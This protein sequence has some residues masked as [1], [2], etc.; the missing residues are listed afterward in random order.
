MS[1]ILFIKKNKLDE[2]GY[3]FIQ[4]T[5]SNKTKRVSLKVKMLQTHF[6]K[7]F[8][9]DFQ[10]FKKTTLLDYQYINNLIDESINKDVFTIEANQYKDTFLSYYKSRILLKSNQ[11][12]ISV[13]TSAYNLLET[14][15]K[16]I[17]K[18]E[19][20]MSEIDKDFVLQLKTYLL[21]G[22]NQNTC[23][24][25]LNAYKTIINNA[26]E[27]NQ[28]ILANP[29]NNVKFKI[30]AKKKRVLNITDINTLLEID[31]DEKYFLA[32]R[33]FLLQFFLNGSRLSDTL[34][35]KNSDI[36]KSEI[37]VIMLKT[38]EYK[39]V[40]M[41][42]EIAVLLFEI[43]F[44]KR[45]HH[46]KHGILLMNYLAKNANEYV[47]KDFI[48][49]N[50]FENYKKENH[51][52][53]EQHKYYKLLLTKYDTQ[54]KKLSKTYELSEIISSHNSRH[55][56]TNEILKLE[57]INV[58]DIRML[59]GHSNIATTQNYIQTGFQSEKTDDLQKEYRSKYDYK[60]NKTL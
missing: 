15:L 6:D 53:I 12:T 9:K 7:T 39:P 19:L 28:Y 33:L 50:I 60:F 8:N 32:S 14:Y 34:L 23:K 52:T 20:K 26:I 31:F 59:L 27:A 47:F 37:S 30:T 54:L 57:N 42:R 21:I 35:L 48:K 24:T 51:F 44:R 5:K 46:S 16:S 55:T 22:R 25:Y 10:R 58:N 2:F 29:F 41:S 49:S 4:Y 3:I 40:S 1:S 18:V 43:V 45:Y 56:F 13:Y 38:K 36:T 17:N 11:S